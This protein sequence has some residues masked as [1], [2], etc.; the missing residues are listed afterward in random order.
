V[1]LASEALDLGDAEVIIVAYELAGV[2]GEELLPRGLHATSPTLLTIGAWHAD[3]VD[4][5]HVRVS[6]RAG[7]RARALLVGAASRGPLTS[8]L[9][10]G[11]A[12]PARVADVRVDRHYDR[13][14][15]TVTDGHAVVLEAGLDDP[16]PIGADDI[17]HVVGL[18]PGSVDG[19]GERLIQ[20]EP[21]L[22]AVRAERGRPVLTRFDGAW[23]GN[24]RLT[25]EH[26]VAATLSLGRLTLPPP[27]FVQ[28]PD[29]PAWE[30]TES[31]AG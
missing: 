26:P 12:Y 3:G 29:V 11:W 5:V 16:R 4:A 14:R 23:F 17:Q 8:T 31:L 2:R 21:H 30:G 18:N 13:V 9:A 10:E 20:V 22:D 6:C 28:R 15:V 1:T 27:R 25:P 24:E 19:R 7:F